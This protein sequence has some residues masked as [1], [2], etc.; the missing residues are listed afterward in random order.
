MWHP[1]PGA[2]LKKEE[3]EWFRRGVKRPE[4]QKCI[5]KEVG[6]EGDGWT[7]DGMVLMREGWWCGGRKKVANN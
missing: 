3:E 2:L 7:M 5:K 6:G 4:K 1:R